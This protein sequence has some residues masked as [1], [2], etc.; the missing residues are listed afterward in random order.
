MLARGRRGWIRGPRGR[1]GRRPGGASRWIGGAMGQARGPPCVTNLWIPDGY[2]DPPAD[3]LGPRERLA[4]YL[5]QIYSK[6][7]DPR[8]N[9]DSVEPKLF[10]IGSESFVAGSHE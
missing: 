2:K 3:R 1:T 6:K 9:L 10:G 4:E 5:D 8:F 7:L